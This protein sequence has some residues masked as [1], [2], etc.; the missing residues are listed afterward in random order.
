MGFN[1]TTFVFE[2][3]NFLVL[4][5][6]LERFVYRPL[7]RGV[8]KRRGELEEREAK[9]NQLT[10]DTQRLERALE[11]RARSIDDLRTQALRD[12]SAAAAS[13]RARILEHAR[14][15]AAAD[16]TR[17]QHLLEAER[18]ASEAE[19]REL[20]IR[21]ST[22][23]AGRLLTQLAPEALEKTLLEALVGE[24]ERCGPGWKAEP[25]TSAEDEVE[26][27][28]ARLPGG[29]T[30]QQLKEAVAASLL[31][32]LTL[33]HREDATLGA[34]AVLRFGHRV[35]DAS[36]AGQ[37]AAVRGRARTLLEEAPPHG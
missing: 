14:E 35:L 20:A 16:R 21:Q 33:V 18:E 37:L 2:L 4:L 6:L 9:A 23:L 5:F 19:V 13:E 8:A 22:A 36:I 1:L 24:L 11:E 10:L 27:T 12:A 28:W 31:P 3:V 34:G 7:R 32:G 15:D 17:A 26:I 25:D 29:A 30:V